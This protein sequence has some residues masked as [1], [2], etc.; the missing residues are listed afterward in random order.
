VGF[1]HDVRPAV[2]RYDKN[3]RISAAP[4]PQNA[5]HAATCCVVKR[6]RSDLEHVRGCFALTGKGCTKGCRSCITDF[7]KET[8]KAQPNISI[9]AF[10]SR[11]LLGF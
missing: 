7:Y 8:C 6:A 5:R 10:Y 1:V 2:L 11:P 4:E 3:S 9:E